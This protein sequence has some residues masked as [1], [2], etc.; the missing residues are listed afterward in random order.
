MIEK[1][2]GTY[3]GRIDLGMAFQNWFYIKIL[4]QYFIGNETFPK[5]SECGACPRGYRVDSSFIC[6]PCVQELQTYDW[7]Y[8]GFMVCLPLISHFLSISICT[9][10]RR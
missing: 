3:C 1:C 5:L 7:F 6:A 4:F 9:Q 8:V 2:P 10:S